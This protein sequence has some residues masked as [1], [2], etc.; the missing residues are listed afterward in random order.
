MNRPS[1]IEEVVRDISLVLIGHC[2]A[3]LGPLES[4]VSLRLVGHR[5]STRFAPL[6]YSKLSR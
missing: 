1:V 3:A 4:N 5:R 6:R 2:T